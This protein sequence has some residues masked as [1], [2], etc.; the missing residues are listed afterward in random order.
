MDESNETNFLVVDRQSILL[1]AFK[2]LKNI[3]NFRT[4]LEISFLGEAAKNFVRPR[5]EFF[6]LALKEMK[7]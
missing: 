6:R 3:T 5:K 1:S 4:T 2:E 7:E